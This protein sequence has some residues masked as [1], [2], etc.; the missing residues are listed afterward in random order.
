MEL[1]EFALY[2]IYEGLIKYN[3]NVK[4]IPLLVNVQ[5]QLKLETIFDTFKVDLIY[6]AAAYKHLPLVEEN[7]CEGSK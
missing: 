1:N 5:D 3:K 7:I 6:H 2:K 4:I